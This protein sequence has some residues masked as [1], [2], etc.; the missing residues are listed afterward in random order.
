MDTAPRPLDPSL[1]QGH[2]AWGRMHLFCAVVAERDSLAG[3]W[4][5][6]RGT[7]LQ[8][9]FCLCARLQVSKSRKSKTKPQT[10]SRGY[11]LLRQWTP[12]TRF[13]A[14]LGGPPGFVVGDT[15]LEPRAFSVRVACSPVSS[16][17]SPTPLPAPPVSSD[18]CFCESTCQHGPG[19]TGPRP[20]ALA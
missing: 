17:P 4:R 13:R 12:H 16:R 20:Q 5:W 2:L 9:F 11:L 8:F 10:L 19:S 1:R 15:L 6:A 18:V 7:L 3:T 14:P